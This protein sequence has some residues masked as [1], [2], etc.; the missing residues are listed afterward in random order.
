MAQR[1]AIADDAPFVREILRQLVCEAGFEC[2]GEACDGQE[3][4]EL[5]TRTRPDIVIMDIVMPVQ[6]GLEAT[7]QILRQLPNTRIVACTTEGQKTMVVQAMQAGCC[8]II[9]KPFKKKDILEALKAA[10]RGP[11]PEAAP[12]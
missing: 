11:E 9:F 1:I 6:S 8:N 3:A 2:V 7:R 4:V 10:I 12:L 5:V